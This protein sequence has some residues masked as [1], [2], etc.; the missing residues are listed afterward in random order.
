MGKYNDVYQLFHDM[1]GDKIVDKIYDN[2]S[3]SSIYFP[4]KLYS[5]EYV[6]SKIQENMDHLT[7]RELARLTGYSERSI[8]RMIN[9]IR[10]DEKLLFIRI[11]RLNL[12]NGR[13][14]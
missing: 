6:L 13:I 4:S 11:R 1:F 10:I 5:K 12:M 3:G 14:F 8:R 7:I 2:F 9:E